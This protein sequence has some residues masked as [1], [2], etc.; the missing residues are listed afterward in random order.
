[1]GFFHTILL[2]LCP[3][4]LSFKEKNV[5][6]YNS[7]P[8]G[9]CSCI[10][11]AIAAKYQHSPNSSAYCKEV[12]WSFQLQLESFGRSQQ[13]FNA[14]CRFSKGVVG[15]IN[16]THMAK[17][18][19][20]HNEEEK[21]IIAYTKLCLM[22]NIK[23]WLWFPRSTHDSQIPL[24]EKNFVP[25]R[26]YVHGDRGYSQQRCRRERKWII[27]SRL[28][29]VYTNYRSKFGVSYWWSSS[30]EFHWAAPKSH[31]FLVVVKQ[32][33]L[34]LSLMKCWKRFWSAAKKFARS[35]MAPFYSPILSTSSVQC[36]AVWGRIDTGLNSF[37][38]MTPRVSFWC[39]RCRKGIQESH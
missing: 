21:D 23:F 25:P 27:T 32:L 4:F 6:H 15:V 24:L 2:S 17:T 8:L 19:P 30:L 39:S 18:A 31:K 10:F 36:T 1:M 35:N 13:D 26:C 22:Q 29:K 5:K 20:N 9:K 37:T 12:Y 3:C 14:N 16:G 28:V 7:E 38:Q 33:L 11:K 34:L